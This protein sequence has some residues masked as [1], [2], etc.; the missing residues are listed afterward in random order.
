MDN[1]SDV[2]ARA[3]VTRS[4]NSFM[5]QDGVCAAGH[6]LR[7][8]SSHIFQPLNRSDRNAVV[9]WNDYRFTGIAVDYS[10]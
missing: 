5:H 6:N 2:F 10:L 9:H 7:D 8:R 3:S 4:N 1:Q